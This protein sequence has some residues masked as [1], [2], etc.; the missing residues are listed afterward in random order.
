MIVLRF[1]IQGEDV[2]LLSILETSVMSL[3]IAILEEDILEQTNVKC[4]LCNLSLLEDEVN[5]KNM[6][7]ASKFVALTY[8]MFLPNT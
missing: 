1:D 5:L 8:N 2:M 7:F 3:Q 4:H 6:N